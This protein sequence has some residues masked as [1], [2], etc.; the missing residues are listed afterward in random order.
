[1]PDD[2]YDDDQHDDQNDTDERKV[3]L[4]RDQIKALEKRPKTEDYNR[5]QRENTLL[6]IGVNSES[7]AGK[8]L[9]GNAD[10]EWDKPEAIKAMAIEAGLIK[11]ETKTEEQDNASDEELNQSQ[12]R[13]D[14]GRGAAGD[15]GKPR[16]DPRTSA[17]DEATTALKRGAKE[18]EAMGHF[19]HRLAEA[20]QAG[21]QRVI[22]R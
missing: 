3:T 13:T 16:T 10:L 21:D 6:K 9:L 18:E 19:I 17:L 12:E 5:L 1:M 11:V 14:L 8:M 4:S 7:P 20:A 2:N 15:D 22:T